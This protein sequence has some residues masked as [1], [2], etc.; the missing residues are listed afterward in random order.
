MPFD[1]M[2]RNG[3]ITVVTVIAA[4]CVFVL[5]VLHSTSGPLFA[6]VTGVCRSCHNSDITNC[7]GCHGQ[8]PTGTQNI[9]PVVSGGGN[10]QVLHHMAGGDLAGGNF[11]YVAD[12]YNPDYTRGHNVVGISMREIAPK[13]VPMGFIGSVVIPGG[14]GPTTWSQTSQLNCAGTWGCH[15]SRTIADNSSAV[16][17]AHHADDSVIDGTSVGK[18]YRFLLG[19]KGKE[20]GKWEYQ[21]TPD[22]HNGYKGDRNYGAMDT[23]SYL[24]G[25]CHGQFHPNSNLGGRTNTNVWHRHPVDVSFGIVAGGYS[26]SEYQA[27][28][29]YNLNVP[30]AFTN[31]T[32][33]ESTVDVN[34]IVTCLSCHRA[35][36]SPYKSM[37]RW[38]YAASTGGSGCATCHTRKNF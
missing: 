8:S 20:H 11:Y 4:V 26:G 17:G 3:K 14:V 30:V 34:S 19:V 31:P 21:A 18:S 12:G 27:Y 25:Q 32:G 13:D 22:N 28:S 36:A 16:A 29:S 15:G 10:P 35:H 24:C 38:D 2:K 7:V 33:T 9:I 23:I 1:K 37:L 5:A 6:V